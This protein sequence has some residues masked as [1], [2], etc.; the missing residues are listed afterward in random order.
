[1]THTSTQHILHISLYFIFVNEATTIG[2]NSTIYVLLHIP[3]KRLQKLTAGIAAFIDTETTVIIMIIIIT[4]T[5]TTTATTT[6]TTTTT[7]TITAI[8]TATTIQT[9]WQYVTQ[10]FDNYNN[11]Q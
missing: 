3:S 2:D 6:I 1:M 9:T 5:T 10:E 7:T 4:T 8:T 11:I